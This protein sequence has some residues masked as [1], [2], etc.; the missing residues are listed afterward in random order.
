MLI[1]ARFEDRAFARHWFTPNMPL[2]AWGSVNAK[3]ARKLNASDDPSKTQR[4]SG[5]LQTD[6]DLAPLPSVAENR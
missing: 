1:G 3:L 2:L 5:D 6:F 4:F